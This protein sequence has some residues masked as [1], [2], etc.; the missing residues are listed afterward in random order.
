MKK[1]G[2]LFDIWIVFKIKRQVFCGK[3]SYTNN[4]THKLYIYLK[5]QVIGSILSMHMDY[6]NAMSELLRKINLEYCYWGFYIR[7]K[8][9]ELFKSCVKDT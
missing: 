8:C 5:Q 1:N 4:N 7:V 3:R 6:K 2:T 9:V